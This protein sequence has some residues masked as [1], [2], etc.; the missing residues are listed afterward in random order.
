MFHGSAPSTHD[1]LRGNNN[2][3]DIKDLEQSKLDYDYDASLVL[4][5]PLIK[6]RLTFF[7]AIRYASSSKAT[8]YTEFYDDLNRQGYQLRLDFLASPSH[9]LTAMY[10]SDPIRDYD[11]NWQETVGDEAMDRTPGHPNRV[12][13]L[14]GS[15]ER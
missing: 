13:E 9:S 10:N 3:D 12:P 8:A 5:G 14:A 6:D 4:G 1:S 2:V 11:L 7:G 15:L